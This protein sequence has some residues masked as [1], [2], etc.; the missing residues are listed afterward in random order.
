MLISAS[1]TSGRFQIT[2]TP[3]GPTILTKEGDPVGAQIP[4]GHNQHWKLR[5][6]YA[7]HAR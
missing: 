2:A 7:P 5:L 6:P 3:S 4:L 1:P